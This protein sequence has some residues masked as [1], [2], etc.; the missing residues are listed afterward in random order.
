VAQVTGLLEDAE[1]L[2]QRLEGSDRL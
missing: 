1:A 2:V